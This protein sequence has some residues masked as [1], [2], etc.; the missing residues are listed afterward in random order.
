MALSEMEQ[1]VPNLTASGRRGGKAQ[2]MGIRA[3]E[4]L[5]ITRSTSQFID[6]MIQICSNQG[7]TRASIQ[8]ESLPLL[9]AN[10]HLWVLVFEVKCILVIN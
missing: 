7:M 8:Q 4:E 2:G 10:N 9:H 5:R 3:L 6:K 1:E